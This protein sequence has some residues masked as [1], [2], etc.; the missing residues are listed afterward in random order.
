MTLRMFHLVCETAVDLCFWLLFWYV[1]IWNKT[2]AFMAQFGLCSDTEYINDMTQAYF[3]ACT[4]I[5]I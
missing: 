4:I 2:D 3:F 1:W 5:L